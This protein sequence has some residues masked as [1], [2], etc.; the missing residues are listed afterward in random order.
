MARVALAWRQAMADAAGEAAQLQVVTGL[1]TT[2][3]QALRA[4]DERFD[5]MVNKVELN[6]TRD[7]K[8][9]VVGVGFEGGAGD[10]AD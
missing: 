2:L 4:H 9:D 7:R 3:L 5:A 10:V 8:I 6:T 1:N